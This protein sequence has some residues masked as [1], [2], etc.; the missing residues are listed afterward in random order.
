MYCT[1]CGEENEVHASYCTSCGQALSESS[2][3]DDKTDLPQTTAPAEFPRPN[4]RDV[5]KTN[6][7]AIASL[8]IALVGLIVQFILIPI[9][10]QL[11]AIVC[12]HLA[13]SDIKKSGGQQQGAGIALAALIISYIDLA[14]FLLFFALV[15]L[16]VYMVA[17]LFPG[18]FWSELMHA[19]EDE[20]GLK[21]L[22]EQLESY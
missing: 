4:Q 9:V 8:V 16:F 1:Q 18:D 19:L 10:P 3:R 13:R 6:R 14:L 12:G 17:E 5:P 2:N 15:V 21:R 22:L 7:L 20:E 11:A